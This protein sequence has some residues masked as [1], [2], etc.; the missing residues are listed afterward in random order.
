MSTSASP[1]LPDDD[2]QTFDFDYE[3]P[4]GSWQAPVGPPLLRISLEF[5]DERI[6][7]SAEV[8]TGAYAII[9]DAVFLE[10]LGIDVFSGQQTSVGGTVGP[11]DSRLTGWI[12][13]LWIRIDD[14][15]FMEL[16]DVV[17][18][19]NYRCGHVLLGREGFLNKWRVCFREKF[20]TMYFALED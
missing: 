8:D 16:V 19:P 1:S 13:S 9:A 4:Y 6:F 18:V 12:H 20:Q 3:V 11:G 14:L 17:A 2:R 15:D 5:G 10:A 7:V